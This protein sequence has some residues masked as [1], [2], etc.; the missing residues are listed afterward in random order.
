MAKE[1][2]RIEPCSL[3]QGSALSALSTSPCLNSPR[4]RAENTVASPTAR[5][6][7]PHGMPRCILLS[8][9]CGDLSALRSLLMSQ[10]RA[11][12]AA[13]PRRTPTSACPGREPRRRTPSTGASARNAALRALDSGSRITRIELT[14]IDG[15]GT[16]RT[17][18]GFPSP[19]TTLCCVSRAACVLYAAEMN[20]TH[21]G[22]R[23]NSS[24]SPSITATRQELFEGSSARSATGR[25]AS[26]T[27]TRCSHARPPATC[28]GPA[29]KQFN[30]GGQLL[31]SSHQGGQ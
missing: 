1:L 11:E 24:G 8:P 28:F 19:S 13:S 16:S 7:T 30:K 6:A 5:R 10:R 31:P 3:T 25:S 9:G 27:M 14:R 12:G 21:M 4:T 23:E 29:Q 26:S 2:N 15:A 18:T 20:Q 17:R 22:G